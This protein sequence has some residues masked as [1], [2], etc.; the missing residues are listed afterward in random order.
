MELL[1]LELS[2]SVPCISRQFVTKNIPP[3]FNFFYFSPNFFQEAFA[4]TCQWSGRP[5]IRNPQQIQSSGVWAYIPALST[6][7][8]QFSVHSFQ[9]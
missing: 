1:Y 9:I 3:V 8:T 5:C 6:L 4:S 2:H 7:L